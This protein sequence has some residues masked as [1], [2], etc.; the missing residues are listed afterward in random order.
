MRRERTSVRKRPLHGRAIK[1]TC[2]NLFIRVPRTFPSKTQRTV[3]RSNVLAGP[4]ILSTPD[5]RHSKKKNKIK[6][7]EKKQNELKQHNHLRFK[8]VKASGFPST[9]ETFFQVCVYLFPIL[10]WM[11]YIPRDSRGDYRTRRLLLMK[12]CSSF[13]FNAAEVIS[14]SPDSFSRGKLLPLTFLLFCKFV[15][16][17]SSLTRCK[18]LGKI[19]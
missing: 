16:V 18:S 19:L 15:L 12:T 4:I 7:R 8:T 6:V 13:I 1:R 2:T 5:R 11:N 3:H 17:P 10:K 9:N 14:F